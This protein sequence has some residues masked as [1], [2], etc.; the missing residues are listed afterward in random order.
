ME[1]VGPSVMLHHRYLRGRPD[2]K[3]KTGISSYSKLAR[4]LPG[5]AL[6]R[7]L[8]CIEMIPKWAQSLLPLP[9]LSPPPP[10]SPPLLPLSLVEQLP[11]S[12]ELPELSL[13]NQ[14]P[15]EKPSF[16]VSE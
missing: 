6:N 15:S 13:E 16:V 11:L 10:Q 3:G 1:A 5:T 7:E 8:G 9:P 12:V 2:A 4:I 14:L